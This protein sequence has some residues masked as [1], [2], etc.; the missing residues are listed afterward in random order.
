MATSPRYVFDLDNY[1]VMLD[2][3]RRIRGL[4]GDGP[5]DRAAPSD[6]IRIETGIRSVSLDYPIPA[7]VAFVPGSLGPLDAAAVGAYDAATHRVAWR[8]NIVPKAGITVSFG[9]RPMGAGRGRLGVGA[10]IRAVDPYNLPLDVDLVPQDIWV[11]GP[12]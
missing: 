8:T 11:F 3:F 5:Q 7:D 6:R 10:T 9:V 12:R 4:L 1:R 2:V